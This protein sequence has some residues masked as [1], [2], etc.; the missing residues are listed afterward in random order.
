MKLISTRTEILS[1]L[2]FWLIFFL[3]YFITLNPDTTILFEIQPISLFGITYLI[4]CISTFYLNYFFVLNKSF[5]THRLSSI[6]IGLIGIF[7]YFIML[8]YL[9]EEVIAPYFFGYSNYIK[10]T[11]IGYYIIDNIHWASPLVLGSTG[12]WI[13]INYIRMMQQEIIISQDNK[14]A[15]IQFLKSQI[16]PHF[17]FNTLNNIYSLVFSKSEKALDA[18]EK[19]SEIMRFTTY[20]TQKELINI[21]DEISYVGSLIDLESIRMT[22]PIQIL[23]KVSFDRDYLE[24]PPYIILPFV[25]N[26]IKHGKIDDSEF[27][28]LISIVYEKSTLVVLVENKIN[29]NQKDSHSGVGFKNLKKRLDFYYPQKYQWNIESDSKNFKSSLKIQL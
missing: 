19:L 8:R 14:Q 10:G 1:H 5:K 18:I 16:N 2:L 26:C 11:S 22:K 24:I 25:E 29:L 3:G 7:A 15:E 6:A 9:L 23:L 4:T 28:A 17:I 12:I 27:P 13:I 20:E 21:N